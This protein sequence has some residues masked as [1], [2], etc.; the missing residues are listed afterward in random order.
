[1]DA[2]LDCIIN[3]DREV[4]QGETEHYALRLRTGCSILLS[5]RI[6]S[7]KQRQPVQGVA[8]ERQLFS[9]LRRVTNEHPATKS[10]AGFPEIRIY[11]IPYGDAQT[12]TFAAVWGIVLNGSK[13]GKLLQG[14]FRFVLCCDEQLDDCLTRFFEIEKLVEIK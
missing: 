11:G 3:W 13:K 9:I 10:R 1:M 4:T 6:T 2:P 14:E 5:N 12:F 7:L 8:V